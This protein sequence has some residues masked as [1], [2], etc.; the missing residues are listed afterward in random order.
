MF[1]VLYAVPYMSLPSSAM[2][3]GSVVEKVVVRHSSLAF[4][5]LY[6]LY[7]QLSSAFS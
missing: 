1:G 6:T 2:K 3:C 4:S 7:E 5:L